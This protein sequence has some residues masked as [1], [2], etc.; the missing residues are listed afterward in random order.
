MP[1]KKKEPPEPQVYEPFDALPQPNKKRGKAGTSRGNPLGPVRGSGRG[2]G[3]DGGDMFGGCDGGEAAEEQQTRADSARRKNSD[4]ERL[5]ENWKK[6][7][8]K[9]SCD[10]LSMAPQYAL[11]HQEE[12]AGKRA[13]LQNRIDSAFKFHAVN[14]DKCM[15]QPQVSS[16][17]FLG[18]A[19]CMCLQICLDLHWFKCVLNRWVLLEFCCCAYKWSTQS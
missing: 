14:C 9:M 12:C 10:L 17:R 11:W 18:L 6:H 7:G 8:P 2:F 3:D 16:C 15:E 13:T 19:A 4:K 5:D 1:K